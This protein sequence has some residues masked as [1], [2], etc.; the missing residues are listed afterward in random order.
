MNN[1]E[2]AGNATTHYQMLTIRAARKITASAS[3]RQTS[4]TGA[5]PGLTAGCDALLAVTEATSGLRMVRHPTPPETTKA[6]GIPGAFAA[7]FR[8][9]AYFSE[10]EIVLKLVESLVP[11]P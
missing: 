8:T 10:V 2:T 9:V 4:C 6:P 11:T 7:D 1:R 3:A 5:S